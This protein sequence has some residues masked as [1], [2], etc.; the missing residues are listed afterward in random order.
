MELPT[1]MH[2]SALF[3]MAGLVSVILQPDGLKFF[4]LPLLV[5]CGP[6]LFA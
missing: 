3:L 1:F 6:A 4:P 2:S 5:A